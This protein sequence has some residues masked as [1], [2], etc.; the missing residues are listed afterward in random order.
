MSPKFVQDSYFECTP[1]H[2]DL[3]HRIRKTPHPMTVAS[4]STQLTVSVVMGTQMQDRTSKSK[5]LFSECGFCVC[6]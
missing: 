3:S 5:M 4:F 6:L 1:S 2:C